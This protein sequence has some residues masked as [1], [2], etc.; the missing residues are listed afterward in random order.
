[1]LAYDYAE[2]LFGDSVPRGIEWSPLGLF[3]DKAT[4]KIASAKDHVLALPMGTGKTPIAVRASRAMKPKSVLIL[5]TSR[6]VISWLRTMWLWHPEYLKRYVMLGSK[7]SRDQRHE[8]WRAHAKRRDLHVIM[9]WQTAARDW[10]VI[11]A[12]GVHFEQVIGD[13]YHKFMRNRGTKAHNLLKAMKADHNLL[14]SGSPMTK[15][16]IDM[17]IPLNLFDSRLFSSYW[18]F[19]GTWCYIDNT[20]HGKQVFGARHP[21]QFRSILAKYAIIASKKQLGLQKKVRAIFDVEMTEIQEDA[22]SQIRDEMILELEEGPPI[23]ALNS[24]VA[25]IRLRQLLTCPAAIDPSLGAGGGI[26]GIYD[27]LSELPLSERHCLIFVPFRNCIAPIKAILEGRGPRNG[28]HDA[29]KE[30]LGVP[31]FELSGGMDI[32]NLYRTLEE[33]KRTGGI[34]ICT[35]Q[36]A[37]SWDCETADKCFFLGADPDPQI[38]FQ[39]EDRLDRITNAHG[40]I[41][42]YYVMHSGCHIDENMMQML[43]HKQAPVNDIY[44]GR[45]NLLAAI[46]G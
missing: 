32:K 24:M 35:V 8:F 11:S 15:G 40:L 20:S 25:W 3:Q 9:N 43:V 10:E 38:N 18:K 2:K 46:K 33:L 22:F 23:V 16:P 21:E 13:E 26:L 1:M 41:T 5:A 4:I 19:A 14:V 31:V 37:E 36:Y 12:C 6:A 27:T 34:G 42:C 45:A 44:N 30:G 17:W 29:P 39:A 7:Y 28:I